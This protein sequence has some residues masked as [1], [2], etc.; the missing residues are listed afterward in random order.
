MG[1]IEQA[2]RAYKEALFTGPSYLAANDDAPH[3]RWRGHLYVPVVTD[4]APD[5]G[6]EYEHRVK[7]PGGVYIVPYDRSYAGVDPDLFSLWLAL[8]QP[9]PAIIGKPFFEEGDLEAIAALIDAGQVD[10]A[11]IE[12]DTLRVL[13]AMTET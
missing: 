13:L 1:L 2:D 5:G 3:W 7:H 9:Q 10:L 4:W 11:S 8:G 12:P 6:Y